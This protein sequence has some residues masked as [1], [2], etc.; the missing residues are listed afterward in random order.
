ML[1]I[2]TK[3]FPLHFTPIFWL[4]RIHTFFFLY[5]GALNNLRAA[6]TQRRRTSLCGVFEG[7][8]QNRS[9]R[10]P[11]SVPTSYVT[12]RRNSVKQPLARLSGRLSRV[13]IWNFSPDGLVSAVIAGGEVNQSNTMALVQWHCFGFF[14]KCIIENCRKIC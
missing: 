1:L 7:S 3:L 8:Q 14:P 11:N 6:Q 10:T 4:K 2:L 5:H 12:R 13:F 9:S